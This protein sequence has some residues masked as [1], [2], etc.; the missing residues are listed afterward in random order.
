MYEVIDLHFQGQPEIIASYV[1]RGRHG[2]ALIETGPGSTADNL[3]GGLEYLGID[4]AEITD[5]L[6]THIHLDH[7]G[8]T[9]RLAQETG[10]RV[11]VHHIGAPHLVDPSRLLISAKRIYGDLMDPLWGETLP[12]PADQI[13]AL[14]DGEI[15]EAAGFRIKALE[16]PGHAYHHMAYL[17]DGLCFTGDVAAVR[18]PGYDHVRLPTPPP[19]I[20]IP[21]WI[22]SLDRL[23]QVRPDRLLPTHFGSVDDDTVGHLDIVAT[24]LNAYVD[25]VRPRWQAGES[26]VDISD[27]FRG[28][29]AEMASSDGCDPDAVHRYEV[30][31]PS[32]M[33]AAGLMRYL[34]KFETES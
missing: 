26:A 21:A 33:Q 29:V 1:L 24:H 3:W 23:R 13:H 14:G 34:Q 16:T 5:I 30:V 2:V 8:A 9:G 25:F 15:I 19:E 11:H 31:V 10:A 28:W 7:A 6:V 27:A 22:A 32:Y 20:N 12:V 18:L 4:P 17:V